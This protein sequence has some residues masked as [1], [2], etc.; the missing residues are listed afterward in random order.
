MFDPQ[1]G[2]IV[3]DGFIERT[4]SPDRRCA[5]LWRRLGSR[6]RIRNASLQSASAAS[7]VPG[8]AR[9]KQRLFNAT[10][11][12]GL[13]LQRSAEVLDGTIVVTFSLDR[14]GPT[15]ECLGVP[16]IRIQFDRSVVVCLGAITVALQLV[17]CTSCIEA[18]WAQGIQLDRLVEILDCPV[19]F[20]LVALDNSR[21]SR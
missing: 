1:C 2:I 13:K 5:R 21:G 9:N 10:D 8:I 14:R 18:E 12:S 17:G 3:G 19:V 11:I 6:G 16:G 4:L 20:A 15:Q 7:N